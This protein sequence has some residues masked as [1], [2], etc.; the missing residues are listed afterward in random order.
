MAAEATPPA[1]RLLAAASRGVLSAWKL[2]GEK[3]ALLELALVEATTNVVRHAY[4]GRPPGP[5]EL[6]LS[7]DGSTLLLAVRDRGTPFDPAAV[8]SPPEPDP[9]DPATWPEGGMG[10]AIIRSACDVLTYGTRDGENTL[11]LLVRLDPA[12]A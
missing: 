8:P 10:V 12:S 4:R 7:R 9:N 6:L 11:T 3:V 5:V 2:P 1:V